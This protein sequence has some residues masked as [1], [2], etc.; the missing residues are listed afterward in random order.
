MKNKILFLVVAL[1][2]VV[3]VA[4]AG[5][6]DVLFVLL[7]GYTSCGS[8]GPSGIGMYAPFMELR[9]NLQ[10]TRPGMRVHYLVGCLGDDAPPAGE[11]QYILSDDPSRELYG[12]TA[13]IMNE[14]EK[15]ATQKAV[16]SL[17]IAG[18]SYGGF[19]AMYMVGKLKLASKLSGLF[20]IDPI[21]TQC[22]PMQVAFGAKVCHQAPDD[23]NNAAIR[24]GTQTWVN[25]YQNQDSWLTSSAIREADNL[26]VQ[27]R[28]P[29]NQIDSDPR[30]WQRIRAALK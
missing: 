6:Q 13:T 21:S 20:T 2:A 1:L 28:G 22:G 29:H 30:T 23:F 3:P 16:G 26:Q 9:K 27:Y 24:A 18:H 7:G 8:A 5:S 10:A 12:N 19:M 17:Y 15:L 4:R 11:G 14:V 25:F